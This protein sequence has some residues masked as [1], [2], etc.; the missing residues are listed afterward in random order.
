M[1][2]AK[3]RLFCLTIGPNV[4]CYDNL[5]C[6]QW[7]RSWRHDYSEFPA[8]LVVTVTSAGCGYDNL[9]GQQWRLSG[10]H[11]DSWFSVWLKDPGGIMSLNYDKITHLKSSVEPLSVFSSKCEHKISTIYYKSKYR[12][13]SNIR[14]TQNQNLNDSRLIMQLHLPN[15]SKPVVKSRMKM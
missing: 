7:W 9:R 12:K 13:I 4:L 3:W 10:Y 5:L 1:S 15:P 11:D 8:N 6:Q 14:R 2:S